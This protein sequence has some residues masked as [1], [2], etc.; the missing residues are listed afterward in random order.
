MASG[1]SFHLPIDVATHHTAEFVQRHVPPGPVVEVGCGSGE[2][3]ATLNRCGYDV[4][5]IDVQAEAVASA[6]AKG[7]NARQLEW[8]AYQGPPC[9]AV[10]FTRSLH[11]MHELDASLA[12]AKDHLLPGGSLIVEDFDFEALG[13]TAM[14][15][16]REQLTA[17][18]F[19]PLM[20][21]SNDELIQGLVNHDAE[22]L[23]S[24]YRS[25][26]L[27]SAQVICEAVARQFSE[28]Q[29]KAAPYLYRYLIRVLPETKNA[30][31]LVAQVKEGETGTASQGAIPWIG[32]RIIA[33][34]LQS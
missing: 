6:L 7:V 19:W 13:H 32:L 20:L 8:L 1:S 24:M 31:D 26:H 16:L 29:V 23:K 3:A 17:T 9:R 15:W 18:D 10:L 22:S 4:T 34:R 2:L 27:H 30:S 25:H 33:S 11:H 28:V 21:A 5:A 14:A 12:L